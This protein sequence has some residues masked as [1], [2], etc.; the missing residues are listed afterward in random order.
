[1]IEAGLDAAA[2]D[3]DLVVVSHYI[4]IGVAIGEALGDDRVV[5]VPMANC[6]ITAIEAGH[7]GLTLVEACSVSHLPAELVTGAGEARLRGQ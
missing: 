4:A 3:G 2:R 7:G 6:A 1:L 5:P